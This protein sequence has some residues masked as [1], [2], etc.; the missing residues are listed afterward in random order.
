MDVDAERERLAREVDKTG[1]EITKLETKLG[2]EQFLAKA[3]ES[4]VEEQRE[5]LEQAQAHR[6]KTEAAL[7]RLQVPD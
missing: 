6:D 4:V 3:P 5:R 1:K 7:A 2:N